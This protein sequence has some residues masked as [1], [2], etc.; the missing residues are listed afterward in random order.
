MERFETIEQ[1]LSCDSSFFKTDQDTKTDRVLKSTKIEQ[2]IYD[3]LRAGSE[4]L[5][6]SE[7]VGGKKLKS[8]DS[9]VNDVFQSIYGITPKFVDEAQLSALSRQFNKNILDSLMSDDDYSAIKSI[10]EG[11]EM[12]AIE[13]TEE[14]TDNILGNLDELM[15]KATGGNGKVDALDKLEKDRQEQ[16]Q[17][18]LEFLARMQEAPPEHQ[19]ALGRKALSAANRALSKKEQTEMFAKLIASSTKENAAGIQKIV[20]ASVAKALERAETAKNVLLSW[21]DDAGEMR[22]NPLNKEILK[23]T[24]ASYKLRYIV[25]FLGRYKEM[26]RSKRVAGYT[27]GRGE[28]YDLEYGNNISK[29]ITSEMSML[30]A[31]ELLSL[32]VKK[33]LGKSL[34]QY[35]RREPAYKGKGDII[36]CLDE[37]SS[38]FGENNAYGMAVAMVLYE[39]CRINHT[40]FALV[41]FSKGTKTEVFL[42]DEQVSPQR[43]MDCAETFLG[44]GTNFDNAL[45]EVNLLLLDGRFEKPDVVFITDGVC[46]VSDEIIEVFDKLKADTGAKLCGILLDKTEHFTFSLEKFADEIYRTSQLFQDEI[47]EKIICE[48]KKI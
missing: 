22:K 1:L 47:V 11:K 26:L 37:S 17:K 30:A 4:E 31:P 20:S 18:A 3:D 24:V 23:R 33:Y 29:A 14:F 25:S 19:N 16:I 46:N 8:F 32:F 2:V 40:N 9:L 43:I 13:A 36:V 21:G 10:C 5:I 42:K 38:T 45:R 6:H 44:G 12:P 35:R 39:L 34:K 48:Y 7:E 28:K 15:R 27:Y 41:H